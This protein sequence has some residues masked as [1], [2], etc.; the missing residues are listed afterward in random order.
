[1]KLF[2]LSYAAIMAAATMTAGLAAS[3]AFA[4][5]E[6]FNGCQEIHWSTFGD[7]VASNDA[8]QL[9]AFLQMHGTCQPLAAT[10]QVL[11]CDLDPAACVAVVEPAAPP[12]TDDY[13]P[14]AYIEIL[15]D[16]AYRA[17]GENIGNENGRNENP[18]SPSSPG[19]PSTPSSTP[20]GGDTGGPSDTGSSSDDK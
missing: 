13:T 11:L 8:D 16:F 6:E 19:S 5:S 18:S 10:A 7:A 2:P 4:E 15:S 1:M 3:P 14:P 20:S 12:P 9:Q 17:P